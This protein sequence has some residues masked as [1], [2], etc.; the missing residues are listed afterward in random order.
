[1]ARVP[2]SFL[3]LL[4]AEILAEVYIELLGGRQATFS[5]GTV[6][7][8]AGARPTTPVF[9]QRPAP[10][11]PRIGAADRAAHAAYVASLGGQPLWQRYREPATALAG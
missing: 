11:P 7:R 5:L 9:R 2:S 8:S 6:L 4:D 1:M 3:A 10:L